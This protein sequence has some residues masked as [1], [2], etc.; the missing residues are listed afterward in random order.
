MSRIGSDSCPASQVFSRAAK[1]WPGSRGRRS[2]GVARRAV[3]VCW[4]IH[5]TATSAT[6]ST[7]TSFNVPST[8]R[9]LSLSERKMRRRASRSRFNRR[10]RCC[11]RRS[12]LTSGHDS[13]L[14]LTI[15]RPP[16]FK[17]ST[18]NRRLNCTTCWLI[19]LR[20]TDVPGLVHCPLLTPSGA[21]AVTPRSAMQTVF[22]S[23][24]D[25]LVIGRFL[26]MKD[27]W[28]LRSAGD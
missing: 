2:S 7:N 1:S 8:L 21:L 14:S 15:A 5:R 10:S 26:L 24:I 22:S 25:A 17:R 28:L 3:A 11:G 12:R 4:G 9:S 19:D 20:R 18:V 23:A 27:Y 16:L 6:T 13:K